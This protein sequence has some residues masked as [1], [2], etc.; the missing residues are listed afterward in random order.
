MSARGDARRGPPGADL[1]LRRLLRAAS[2]IKGPRAVS[3][4]EHPWETRVARNKPPST[5]NSQKVRG[6]PRTKL[7][8][9]PVSYGEETLVS[10]GLASSLQKIRN[11]SC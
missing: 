9:A 1:P 2:G 7:A 11:V 6:R 3:D 10:G 8:G 5:F 4:N